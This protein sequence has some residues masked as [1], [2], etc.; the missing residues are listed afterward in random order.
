MGC[1]ASKTVSPGDFG[2]F[3]KPVTLINHD[4]GMSPPP[5]AP[6]EPS[7][8]FAAN[9]GLYGTCKFKGKEA[10]KYLAKVG[11]KSS[12][13]DDKSWTT[14]ASKADKI[15]SAILEWAKD[16]GECKRRG[17]ATSTLVLNGGARAWRQVRRCTRT[18]S[19]RSAPA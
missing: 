12:V 8:S 7:I 17:L 6:L 10:D 11:L 2:D 1:G 19:S 14:D 4:N 18:S 15:A 5:S 9:L 3:Q 16:H 13:L